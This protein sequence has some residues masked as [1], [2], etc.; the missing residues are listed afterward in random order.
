MTR[1]H[2][3]TQISRRNIVLRVPYSKLRKVIDWR[4]TLASNTSSRGRC[5]LGFAICQTNYRV[6]PCPTRLSTWP[7]TF[8]RALA[9]TICESGCRGS[10][11]AR[12]AR[13]MH[14]RCSRSTCWSFRRTRAS[15]W[16]QPNLSSPSGTQS[17]PNLTIVKPSN[18][19]ERKGDCVATS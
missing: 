12:I 19:S 6:H 8:R 1:I 16:R 18:G 17:K 13:R 7:S 9:Q 15:N 2:E 14:V 4:C 11:F 10:Y 3:R 5:G